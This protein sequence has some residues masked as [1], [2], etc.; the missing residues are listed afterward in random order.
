MRELVEDECAARLSRGG[1]RTSSSLGAPNP[2]TLCLFGG[3]AE[4]DEDDLRIYRL[5]IQHET[6]HERPKPAFRNRARVPVITRF[7]NKAQHQLASPTVKMSNAVPNSAEIEGHSSPWSLPVKTHHRQISITSTHT[8]SPL[9]KSF[10]PMDGPPVE[11]DAPEFNSSTVNA[12][13]SKIRHRRRSS[14]AFVSSSP[15]LS[16]SYITSL[17]S[18]R[19]TGASAPPVNFTLHLGVTGLPPNCPPSLRGPPHI[20]IPFEARWHELEGPYSGSASILDYYASLPPKSSASDKDE[21]GS[22]S[23]LAR[24]THSQRAYGYRIPPK[25]K[26]QLLLAFASGETQAANSTPPLKH[27]IVPYDLLDMKP[28]NQTIYRQVWNSHPEQTRQDSVPTSPASTSSASTRETLRYAIELHFVSPPATP[29]PR[30]QSRVPSPTSAST[31]LLSVVDDALPFHIEM[32]MDSELC[33][34]VPKQQ[35]MSGNF[36]YV[37]PEDELAKSSRPKIYLSSSI[38]L[39]FASHPPEDDEIMTMTI[40]WGSAGAGGTSKDIKPMY[41]PYSGTL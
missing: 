12:G 1:F 33:S 38:R 6:V 15:S 2:A 24:S 32:E 14:A 26:L 13:S 34:S 16:G 35:T 30:K 29:R 40:E 19:M 22:T 3:G 5:D 17:L 41:F 39:A 25:G 20:K 8:S 7:S 9:S 36:T 37:L 4:D 23:S 31:S 10:G 28:G 27:F 11:E 21:H 18:G